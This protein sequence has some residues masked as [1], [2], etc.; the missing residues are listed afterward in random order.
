ML[1]N[2][3]KQSQ[4]ELFDI[5]E[6][7]SRLNLRWFAEIGEY[8][9]YFKR[10]VEPIESISSDENIIQRISTER[11]LYVRLVEFQS[12]LGGDDS[13]EKEISVAAN[14]SQTTR[15]R[16]SKYHL[17]V[18][19]AFVDTY[20]KFGYTTTQIVEFLSEKGIVTSL[21]QVNNVI[22]SRK[23]KRYVSIRKRSSKDYIDVLAIYVKTFMQFGFKVSEMVSSLADLGI[24]TS[25]KQINN[26][27]YSRDLSRFVSSS[28]AE[29]SVCV[30]E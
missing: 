1:S 21:K 15:S 16:A 13:D 30:Y 7:L 26:V 22:D 19:E 9:F 14:D 24:E 3:E 25:I 8:D 12:L 4:T 10:F 11:E 5:L 18:V 6:N 2:F 17:T 29:T 27:I 20:R 23:L 28:I